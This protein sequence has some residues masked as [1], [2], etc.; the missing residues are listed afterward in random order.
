MP[1]TIESTHWFRNL[2]LALGLLI[3]SGLSYGLLANKMGFFLDDWYIIGTYRAFGVSRFIEY[4]QGDRPLLSYVYLIFM[5]IFKDSIFG[6]QIF[7]LIAKWL[8]ALALWW[9]LNLTMPLRRFFNYAVAL[10]FAI[11]PGFQ[12]HNYVIMYSQTYVLFVV[13][14]LSFV[15]MVKAIQSPKR[16]ILY[17]LLAVICQFIGLVPM[18]YFYGLEFARPVLL[19][20]LIPPASFWKRLRLTLKT[21]WPYAWVFFG[22]TFFR[23]FNANNFGYK[24]GLL[25][26][27]KSA[28]KDTILNLL[29]NTSQ[30]LFETCLKVWYQAGRILM[31]EFGR[32]AFLLSVL[33]AILLFIFLLIIKLH[34]TD[35]KKPISGYFIFFGL[36]L[37]LAA[38]A[39]FIAAGFK[40]TLEFPS[41]RF[42]LPLSI[43]ASIFSVSLIDWSLRTEKQKL[44]LLSILACLSIGSNFLVAQEYAN[45]WQAQTNFFSQLVW[46]APQLKPNTALLTPVF[47]FSQY[48]SGLSLTAPLNAIYAPDHRG[49]PLPYYIIQT[50]SDER[51]PNMDFSVNKPLE[52]SGRSLTFKG[53]TSE[54]IALY[55]PSHGCLQV[56]SPDLNPAAFAEDR[57]AEN[58]SEIIPLSNLTRIEATTTEPA[59]LP[60]KY[61]GKV[62]TDNWCYYFQKAESANQQSNWAETTRLWEEVEKKGLKPDSPA[63][64]LPFIKAILMAGNPT[65]AL[66]I[67]TSLNDLD[68]FTRTNLCQIWSTQKPEIIK[69]ISGPWHLW[70]CEGK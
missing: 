63:D 13:Y 33:S 18:E 52:A 31:F 55:M 35:L 25:E 4:F 2:T 11:F 36:F 69:S 56:L 28:P 23:I 44:F 43:G 14:L 15:F 19:F 16:Y 53:N 61:F 50:A 37:I 54:T 12:F 65:A 27:L 45:A 42:M 9:L 59:Q 47:P 30:T 62:S 46:R 29:V 41:N 26:Q 48:F 34:K 3:V 8:S 10:I 67:S 38:M 7:A 6:W 5:P 57:Y 68:S 17:I 21:Y 32:N 70:Q 60:A 40:I 1:K 51:T 64:Y 20:L 58:W 22:F 24:I 66:E 39:P 49:N